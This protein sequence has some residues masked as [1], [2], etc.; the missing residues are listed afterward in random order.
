MWVGVG[1]AGDS[2]G[3]ARVS[4]NTAGGGQRRRRGIGRYRRADLFS[5][6]SDNAEPVHNGI[7]QSETDESVKRMYQNVKTIATISRIIS[8][9]YIFNN[10]TKT[11]SF[12]QVIP[13]AT[14]WIRTWSFLQQMEKREDLVTGCNRLE[15]VARDLYS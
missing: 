12:M 11:T 14:H 10:N 6:G 7:R 4:T 3:G 9:D 5:R 15:K 8:R 2:R 1:R 13:L